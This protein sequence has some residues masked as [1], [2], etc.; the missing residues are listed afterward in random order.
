[1]SKIVSVQHIS[2]QIKDLLILHDCVI[3]PNFGAFVGNQ[4][5]AS[6]HP[7]THL[8]LAPSKKLLFNKNITQDDGL[9]ISKLMNN[10]GLLYQEAKQA[11]A[12]YVA[13]AQ[14]KLANG[15]AFQIEEVGEIKPDAEQNWVF[16]QVEDF[17]FSVH[18]YGLSAVH[19]Q[20]VIRAAKTPEKEESNIKPLYPE[21]EVSQT[22]GRRNSVSYLKYIIAPAIAASVFAVLQ[23]FTPSITNND[24][25]EFGLVG[26]SKDQKIE[27]IADI[28][29]INIYKT[30]KSTMQQ[31][32][33]NFMLETAKFYP[34]AASFAS[35][36]NANK[37]IEELKEMGFNSLIIDRTPIGLYRVG[38]GEFTSFTSANRELEAIRKSINTEAWLLVK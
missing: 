6:M 17:N 29:K 25:A 22:Y 4:L 11:I 36:E 33:A 32:T 10:F 30:R 23:I 27:K 12:D 7:V 8:I 24:F 34:V 5:S 15:E 16:K 2:Q 37:H 19:I 38:Y 9:L 31:S 21:K 28:K 3:I 13:F 14:L 18:A 1:M 20:P 35:L 26:N